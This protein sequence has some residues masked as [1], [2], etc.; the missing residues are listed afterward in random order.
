MEDVI[1]KTIPLLQYSPP[2]PVDFPLPVC[3]HFR[4]VFRES[5]AR[6]LGQIDASGNKDI[7]YSIFEQ[8]EPEQWPLRIAVVDALSEANDTT[9]LAKMEYYARGELRPHARKKMEEAI[10]R[11]KTRIQKP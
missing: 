2:P 4:E 6:S 7:L 8:A 5:A 3:I 1:P 11:M 10:Q 9:I